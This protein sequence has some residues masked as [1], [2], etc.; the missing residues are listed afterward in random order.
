M[1]VR[2]SAPGASRRCWRR[3]R[4][5]ELTG[6]QIVARL[7]HGHGIATRSP[8][9]WRPSNSPGS[10]RRRSRAS[11]STGTGS[12]SNR[13]RHPARLRRSGGRLRQVFQVALQPEQVAEFAL[14]ENPDC[15]VEAGLRR[16]PRA[17][18]FEELHGWLMHTGSTR[19]RPTCCGTC[20]ATLSTACGTPTPTKPRPSAGRGA[21]GV[22]TGLAWW[23]S[24]PGR[25][26]ASRRARGRTTMTTTG[27][28]ATPKCWPRLRTGAVADEEP[29]RPPPPN[30]GQFL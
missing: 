1:L 27:D 26:L 4:H 16:D 2:P 28:T 18:R 8:R 19:S 17:R 30:G 29:P 21:R 10:S 9:S 15:E 24:A 13:T 23:P 6:C 22:V 12:R 25:A 5:L 3:S 14:P 11:G 7:V 20:S